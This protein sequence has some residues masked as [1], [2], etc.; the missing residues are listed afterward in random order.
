MLNAGNWTVPTFNYELRPD[1]PAMLYWLQMAAYRQFG[2]N[3]FAARLPSAVASIL[4]VLLTYELGRRLYGRCTGV[5]AGSVLAISPAFCAAAHF[6]YPDVLLSLF[7]LFTMSII[8]RVCI[9]ELCG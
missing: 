7:T 3:E 1:K 9:R 4:T 2:I 5:I 8:C 6:A